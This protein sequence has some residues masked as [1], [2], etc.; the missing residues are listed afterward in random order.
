MQ[1][2]TF[3]LIIIRV[4]LG[5]TITS[6]TG[7]GKSL[8]TDP[9]GISTGGGMLSTGATATNEY[10]LRPVAINVSVQ[11]EHDGLSL[12]ESVDDKTPVGGDGDLEA[13]K[14]VAH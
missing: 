2:V 6:A 7:G 4:G 9:R 1:G 8:S 3:T 13:G 11:R 12:E 10:P 5:Y 14:G